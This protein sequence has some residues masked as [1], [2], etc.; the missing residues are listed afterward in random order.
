MEL[1][2]EIAN[3]KNSQFQPNQANI[4]TIYQFIFT[5]FH[6]DLMKIWDFYQLRTFFGQSYFFLVSLYNNLSQKLTIKMK[7]SK[8]SMYVV[9]LHKSLR[10][11]NFY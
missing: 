6:N 9:L 5:Q 7:G 8:M 11:S 2:Q 3:N 1:A 10:T 4:L